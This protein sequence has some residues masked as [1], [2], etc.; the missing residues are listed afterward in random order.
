MILLPAATRSTAYG[1]LLDGAFG[2]PA[3][4][5]LARRASTPFIGSALA[6]AFAFR[7]G[8]FN[9]GV[10]G[11]LLVGAL[12]GRVGRDLGVAGRPPRRPGRSRWCCSPGSWAACSGA[13]I[14]GV[15]K[16]RT[17]A[18]EVITTIMLNSIALL[19]VAGW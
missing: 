6:V 11:Q 8:L 19:L 1:A 12:A 7:A 3:P 2:S 17:G 5:R 15:L 14:A 10:E 4:R 18:H 13:A 16:A 9:I